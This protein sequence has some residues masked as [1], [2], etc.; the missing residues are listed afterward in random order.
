MANRVQIVLEAEDLA[1]GVL[2]GIVSQFGQFGA[3]VSDASDVV[4]KFNGFMDLQK[5]AVTDASITADM[6]NK[7]YAEAGASMAR[8]G[9]TIAIAV[10]QTVQE[11]I[12]V[13]DE[14]NE[15][16]R[17]LSLVS[18]ESAENTSRF[19]QVL[20]DFG[21]TADDAMVA[22][23]AL[24]EKGLSPNIETLAALADEFKK[25]KDPAERMAFVQENLGKG[26]AKWVAV[27]NQESSALRETAASVDKYLVKTDE[28]I[29]KAEIARLAIDN[30]ADSWAA[31]QNRI[32]DAKNEL[33]FA[34]EA[35]TR[36][37]EILSK[38]GVAIN[39]NTNK[40]QEYRD[41]LEQAKKELLDSGSASLEYTES[42]AEQEQAAQAAADALVE[43]SKA[44]QS[45]VDGAIEI[46]QRNKDYQ[47][48]QD[49]IIKKIADTRAEGEKLYPWEAE[50]IEENKQKL[51]E[52]GQA[53]FDNVADFRAAMEEKAA[54]MAVE[55]I[56]LSDGIAGFSDAEFEKAKKILETQDIA[57]AAAFEE[58]QA[59]TMLADA[60]ASGILPVENWGA[61]MDS[62][63]ADSVVSVAEVQAAIDA[64][65]KQNTVTFDIV[66]N[67]APPNLDVS[68]GSFNAPKGTHRSSHFAG[69]DYTIPLSYGTEGF[70]LGGGDTASGGEKL[71][72]SSGGNKTDEKIIALLQALVSKPSFTEYDLARALQSETT[73]YTR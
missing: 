36:A 20:D 45:L 22:A 48:S 59:M 10:V 27:L 50:K 52:L 64:V 63:M 12:K 17:D 4:G 16:I 60:V 33:I 69:G 42:L 8:L 14:Y 72:I 7:S 73:R 38:N 54:L 31:F 35:S 15:S 34:N 28:Q 58:Q 26:G 19:I 43:L 29:K 51:E 25:I 6:L 61:T 5:R 66:T 9:E 55:Q 41:A 65:P 67:G 24:K 21:L 13:T 46:T 49:D 56:A 47:Q 18:G 1:S 40:T 3:V 68:T 11:A 44:N 2:R 30:L 62:V 32:G 39:A 37:Y 57:T 53:Y 71:S 70:M 23:K